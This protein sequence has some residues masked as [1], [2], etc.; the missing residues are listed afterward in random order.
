MSHTPHVDSIIQVDIPNFSIW[1]RA[2]PIPPK[3]DDSLSIRPPMWVRVAIW[4]A[5]PGSRGSQNWLVYIEPENRI[6][7]GD[8]VTL[9]LHETN[10]IVSTSKVVAIR[11]MEKYFIEYKLSSK[12]G[13]PLLTLSVPVVWTTLPPGPAAWYQLTKHRRCHTYDLIPPALRATF[14]S[15]REVELQPVDEAMN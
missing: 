3:R 12:P 7:L 14:P 6:T 4:T 15:A 10:G 9:V 8:E 13:H 1:Y 5:G 2:P 11:T